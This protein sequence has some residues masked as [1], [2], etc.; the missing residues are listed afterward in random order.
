MG[1][2]KRIFNFYSCTCNRGAPG[3]WN[4]GESKPAI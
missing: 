4:Q 1:K 3:P 2:H